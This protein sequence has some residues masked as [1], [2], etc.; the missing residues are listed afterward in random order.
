MHILD[1]QLDNFRLFEIVAVKADVNLDYSPNAISLTNNVF[2]IKKNLINGVKIQAAQTGVNGSH[3]I[4][5]AA[6]T[7]V[8]GELYHLTIDVNLLDQGQPLPFRYSVVATSTTAADLQL[9]F[10]N[11]ITGNQNYLDAPFTAHEDGSGAPSTATLTIVEAPKGDLIAG[12]I[13]VN[14]IV[15]ETGATIALNDATANL[16]LIGVSST[17]GLAHVD[18]FGQNAQLTRIKDHAG[19]K[20][21]PSVA[22]AINFIGTVD[23]TATYT[24]VTVDYYKEDESGNPVS[25]AARPLFR[26][27]IFTPTGGTDFNF[28][29]SIFQQLQAISG[30][31]EGEALHLA[32]NTSTAIDRVIPI[33]ASSVKVTTGTTVHD[34]FVE[35]GFPVGSIFSVDNQDSGTT[36][37][38]FDVVAGDT[39]DTAATEALTTGVLA[40]FMKV[41]VDEWTRMS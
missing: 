27:V 18:A 12:E 1:N 32:K 2:G 40:T 26:D 11:A 14:Q 38:N 34:I 17:N 36:D 3:S 8:A 7:I 21:T 29:L 35:A 31:G 20:Q 19:N 9:L 10:F 33:G 4:D 24:T 13:K 37:V 41:S 39:V 30:T 23:G 5:F 25:K 15:E 6:G 16:Y 22:R 28:I